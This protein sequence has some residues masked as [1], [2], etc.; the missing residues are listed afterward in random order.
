MSTPGIVDQNEAEG[1]QMSFLNAS[2]AQNY[3]IKSPK[4]NFQQS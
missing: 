3:D 1:S 2:V 4:A